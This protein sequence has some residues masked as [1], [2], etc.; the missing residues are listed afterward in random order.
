MAST[1]KARVLKG[2]RDF[3]P[4]EELRRRQLIHLLEKCFTSHG[5]MPIDTPTLEYADVLLSKMGDE[6]DKQSYRFTDGGG[7]DVALRFD[8]TVPLARFVA[9]N[10]SK[11]T[12]PFRRYHVGKVWRGEN[13]QR[14]RFREFVQCD[15]DVVGPDSAGADLE[16]MLMA[17][18]GLD[19]IGAGPVMIRFSHRGLFDLLLDGLGLADNH[20]NVLRSVDKTKKIGNDGVRAILI[21]LVGKRKA[22]A[23]LDFIVPETDN[24]KTL[25]KML[26]HIEN[27]NRERWAKTPKT[28]KMGQLPEI[29]RQGTDKLPEVQRVRTILSTFDRLGLGDML[30]LDPSIA[31]GLDYYTGVV[32]EIF[33]ERLPN[34]GS[35]CSGGRYDDLTSL[36]L[37]ES[38]S[39]VGASIG[40]DRLRVGLDE[41]GIAGGT[42]RNTDLLVLML[43]ET[44]L[45]DYQG[46]ARDFRSSGLAVEVYP[47]ERKLEV[48]FRYA[49]VK[50]IPFALLYGPREAKNREV[51][52]KNLRT[53]ESFEALSIS[54]AMTKLIGSLKR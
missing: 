3:L 52:L 13:T 21:D 9:S 27:V 40:L 30:L 50:G 31:R 46:F 39:G 43:D 7:R 35:V 11:L 48:Q 49:Q 20:T 6:A 47:E 2:F 5:Y 42:E 17:L 29:E 44:L 28:R 26:Q 23:I 12:L 15:F 38:I 14:G 22:D 32:F 37:K 34:I 53:R 51:N 45:G 8:L 54:A 24:G 1:V 36:F 4:D 25:E 18:D 41:L 10:R 16:I 33:L 19:V